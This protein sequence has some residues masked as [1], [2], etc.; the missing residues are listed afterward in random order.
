[1]CGKPNNLK[2][3]GSKYNQRVYTEQ[4]KPARASTP[5]GINSTVQTCQ[6]YLSMKEIDLRFNI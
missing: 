5:K 3:S 4:H 6:G 1:M 2:V